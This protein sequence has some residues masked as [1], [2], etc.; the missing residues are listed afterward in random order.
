M[1][2]L[3]GDLIRCKMYSGFKESIK[4]F[5][6]NFYPGFGI[7]GV[8]FVTMITAFVGI[9]FIPF[10]AVFFSLYWLPS[11]ILILLSKFLISVISKSNFLVEILAHPVQ[12]II[13]YITGLKSVYLTKKGKLEWKGRHL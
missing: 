5:T 6:K 3:G 4:G 10:I 7:S 12:V 2:A 11:V 13:L 9:Y 1:T 8:T